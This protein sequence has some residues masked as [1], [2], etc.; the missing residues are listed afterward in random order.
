M[1][2]FYFIIMITGSLLF[3]NSCTTTGYV[4][5]E[6]SYVEYA[7]PSRPSETHIWIDGDWVYHRQNKVYVRKHGNWHKPKPNRT[8]VSGSWQSSSQGMYWQSGYWR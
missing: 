6:P 4:S 2:K 8:Y 7:R 1:K 5:S 3:F